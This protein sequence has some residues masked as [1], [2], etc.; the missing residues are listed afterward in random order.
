MKTLAR[1]SAVAVAFALST[2]ALS[3]QQAPASGDQPATKQ[4]VVT[5]VRVA[6]HSWLDAEVYLDDD[7]VLVPLGFVAAQQTSS[8]TIRASAE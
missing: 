8:T 7:G 2:A 1:C 6:N 5:Q 3:A 4:Q